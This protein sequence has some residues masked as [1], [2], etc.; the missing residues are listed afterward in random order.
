MTVFSIAI[1]IVLQNEGVT[2]KVT[3]DTGGLTKYGI[4]QRSY[5]TLNIRSLSLDDAEKIY[6]R[7]YYDVLH[8]DEVE[9]LELVIKLLDMAVN[10]GVYGTI[11]TVQR[12]VGVE[13]DGIMGEN[14]INSINKQVPNDLLI[15][16]RNEQKAFYTALVDNNPQKYGKYLQGWLNRV[17][18][19]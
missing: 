15:K 5:P 1:A 14:T 2:G 16:L 7:D 10:K 3:I 18:S 12:I 8:L 9:S 11:K 19:C 13:V 6:K 4:C 17:E